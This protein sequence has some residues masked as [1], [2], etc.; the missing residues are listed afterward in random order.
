LPSTSTNERYKRGET[1]GARY[2]PRDLVDAIASSSKANMTCGP[3]TPKLEVL[4][5]GA[6]D[7]AQD[8]ARSA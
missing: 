1:H 2:D 8:G 7:E 4:R 3:F 5:R 6:L